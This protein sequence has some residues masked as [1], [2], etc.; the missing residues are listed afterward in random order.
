[1]KPIQPGREREIQAV[2]VPVTA[3]VQRMRN[4]WVPSTF[5]F[6]FSFSNISNRDKNFCGCV[7]GEG[8]K[9]YETNL[10]TVL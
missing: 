3:K 1:V 8:I 10:I 5:H 4:N 6:A 9:G 2:S 7:D